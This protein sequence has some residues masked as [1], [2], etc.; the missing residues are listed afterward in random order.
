MFLWISWHCGE[1]TDILVKILLL[2]SH[3][4][5]W[6]QESNLLLLLQKGAGKLV[7]NAT[8]KDWF[9]KYLD[10]FWGPKGKSAYFPKFFYQ[11]CKEMGKNPPPPKKNPTLVLIQI[12]RCW[13]VMRPKNRGLLWTHVQTTKYSVLWLLWPFQ[14]ISCCD[15]IMFKKKGYVWAGELLGLL[16]L[17]VLVKKKKKKGI[18]SFYIKETGKQN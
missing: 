4:Q 1:A 14:N 12:A 18:D 2:H 15:C 5:F 16:F 11:V 6:L 10:A 8:A 9:L 3:W 7:R 13:H 17:L